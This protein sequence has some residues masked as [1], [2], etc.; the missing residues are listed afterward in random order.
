M[1]KIFS[2]PFNCQLSCLCRLS[3]NGSGSDGSAVLVVYPEQ[4][5]EP[6]SV[7]K[8]GTRSVGSSESAVQETAGNK[9]SE[10]QT[11]VRLRSLGSRH[12]LVKDT[13]FQT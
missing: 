12:V 6:F 1:G 4:T 2:Q 5:R 10:N 13:A 9:R 3:Q 7:N 11:A 8:D